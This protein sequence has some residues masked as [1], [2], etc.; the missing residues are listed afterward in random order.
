MT[1]ALIVGRIF[2]DFIA[3]SFLAPAG[4]SRTAADFPTPGLDPPSRS[5]CFLIDSGRR[6][7]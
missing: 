5:A 3:A 2:R 7:T 1:E 6:L 4:A